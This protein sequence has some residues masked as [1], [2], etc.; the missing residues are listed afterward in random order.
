M[1]YRSQPPIKARRSPLMLLDARIPSP[2]AASTDCFEPWETMMLSISGD[3]YPCCEMA[4]GGYR[5]M[6]N[7]NDHS[8]MDVWNGDAYRSLRATVNSETP[9]DFCAKCP[10][11]LAAS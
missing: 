1:Y 10:R 3:V 6:G 11:K 7:V 4:S 8:F 2:Y 9:P 5:V